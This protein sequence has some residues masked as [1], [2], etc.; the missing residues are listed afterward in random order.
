MRYID[1]ERRVSPTSIGEAI[2]ALREE[3]TRRTCDAAAELLA[4]ADELEEMHEAAE[5]G[6]L[7]NSAGLP[8]GWKSTPAQSAPA[9][10]PSPL[11][12]VTPPVAQPSGW[13]ARVRRL[14]G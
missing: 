6:D 4:M 7:D 14:F 11:V 10:T 5:R 2:D 1:H 3:A 8:P 9:D 13:W 12:H